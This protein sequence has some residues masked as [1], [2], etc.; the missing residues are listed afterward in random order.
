MKPRDSL[1][2]TISLKLGEKPRFPYYSGGVRDHH[3]NCPIKVA[4]VLTC[5][6]TPQP[7]DAFRPGF[8]DRGQTIYLARDL[9]RDVLPGLPR[10]DGVPDPVEFAE[11]FKKPW[12]DAGY[13][14]FDDPM[15]NK[16]H[17]GQWVGQAVGNA[18]LALCMDFTPEQKDRLLVNLV[19]VGID[20]WGTV[21]SGHPGWEGWGGHGSGR[22]FAIV[23]GGFML[24]DDEM[25]SPTRTL[26]KVNFGEDN[27]TKYGDGWTGAKVV[28]TGHSG[29]HADGSVPRPRWGPYEHMHPSEWKEVRDQK[30]FQSEGYRRANTS[31]CWVGEALVMRILKLEDR[32]G[33]DAFFDYVD[34]WMYEDD[35]EFR[36]VL[37]QY[38][39][40]SGNE[41]AAL[42]NPTKTWFHQGYTGEAWVK[43]AWD[44]Y[45]SLSDAPTDGWKKRKP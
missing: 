25:A 22:K 18:G 20:Y 32:W 10:I 11:V 35:T 2:S 38:W 45:R 9:R 6:E 17:Y 14:E 44:R 29:I 13:F 7:P 28:Y 26:P 16:P 43:T 40:G 33:H 37:H 1:V 31:C 24:G 15:E 27:Q 30:N 41:K 34:R 19:Q 39:P 12:I 23:F 5:V 3:D 21:K 36:H 42:I 4:A 8:C